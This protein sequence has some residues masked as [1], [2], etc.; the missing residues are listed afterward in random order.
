MVAARQV[1]KENFAS[2]AKAE[3]LKSQLE[4]VWSTIESRAYRKMHVGDNHDHEHNG[5]SHHCELAAPTVFDV[6]LQ[7]ISRY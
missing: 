2:S 1:L 6:L 5:K 4:N 3:K 7:E